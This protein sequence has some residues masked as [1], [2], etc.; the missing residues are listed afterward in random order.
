M[1]NWLASVFSIILR[2][3]PKKWLHKRP[4]IKYLGCQEFH[5]SGGWKWIA[6]EFECINHDFDMNYLTVAKFFMGNIELYR[7]IG[8]PFYTMIPNSKTQSFRSLQMPIHLPT[9]H[10]TLIRFSCRY[11]KDSE[12]DDIECVF[13]DNWQN[14]S[15]KRVSISEEYTVRETEKWGQH[16]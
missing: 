12:E 13:E 5:E 14:K 10:L 16:F 1:L 2:I 9:K 15:K 11:P 8:T 7:N 4:K 6:L 3:L